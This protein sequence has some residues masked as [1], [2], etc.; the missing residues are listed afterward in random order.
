[1]SEKSRRT[2]GKKQLKHN[3]SSLTKQGGAATNRAAGC[4]GEKQ[5]A[6]VRHLPW[7]TSTGYTKFLNGKDEQTFSV[8]GLFGSP[9][10]SQAFPLLSWVLLCFPSL[11]T[12]ISFH[13]QTEN[14]R[15]RNHTSHYQRFEL[16]T[17][18][19]MLQGC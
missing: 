6:D 14:V 9:F 16:R 2:Q 15:I 4:S 19:I 12:F 18:V 11:H 13:T 17:H 10:K 7:G 5:A 8:P 1:M 3:G